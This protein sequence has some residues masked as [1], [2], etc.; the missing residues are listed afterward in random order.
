MKV[1]EVDISG[2]SP[3]F[4][5][6]HPER[7]AKRRAERSKRRVRSG[8]ADYYLGDLQAQLAGISRAADGINAKAFA[9]H[10]AS[11]S[12]L[13]FVPPINTSEAARKCQKRIAKFYGLNNKYC[14]AN[15]WTKREDQR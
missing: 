10:A 8:K 15:G 6:R 5:P 11:K 1:K 4:V 2:V 12:P 13:E 14:K 3:S 9:A 7:W